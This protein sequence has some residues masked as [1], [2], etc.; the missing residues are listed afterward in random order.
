MATFFI[1]YQQLVM[2][3]YEGKKKNNTLPYGLKHLTPAKLKAECEMRCTQALNKRDQ[4]TIREF[5]GDLDESKTPLAMIKRCETDRFRPLVNYLKGKSEKTDEKNVELLAWLLDFQN[6]PWELNKTYSDPANPGIPEI[7]LASMEMEEKD[8]RSGPRKKKKAAITKN[9]AAAALISLTLGTAA[10][11][12]W[13]DANKP[14]HLGGGCMF[15]KED[16]YEPVAC[17]E[18][19]A[20]VMVIAQDSVKLKNFRKITKPDTITY[21]SLGRVWYAKIDGEIEYFT[22]PGDHP[23]VFG[24]KLKP[25]TIYI[26]N[27]Y[28]LSGQTVN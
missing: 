22:S 11:W 17:N 13:K 27:K 7:Q 14:Q 6:R 15:W 10:T 2:Q 3:A 19:V 24:R 8:N 16:H 28:I 12:W 1:D 23:V 20:H 9:F 18:K 5:C 21:Q 26:I 4:R 25:I